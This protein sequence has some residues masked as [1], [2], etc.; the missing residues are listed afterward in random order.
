[1]GSRASRDKKS[2]LKRLL[3]AAHTT[4]V[5]TTNFLPSNCAD[6]HTQHNI[7]VDPATKESLIWIVG[8]LDRLKATFQGCFFMF[9]GA[10]KCSKFL[11]IL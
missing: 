9:S 2:G 11:K 6:A 1:L 5:L 7:K 10:K 3:W 8:L 4:R